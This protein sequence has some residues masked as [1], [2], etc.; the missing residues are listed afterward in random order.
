[1]QRS[2]RNYNDGKKCES[3]YPAAWSVSC[4]RI[5]ARVATQ[6][7]ETTS[8]ADSF[9][10]DKRR[11]F[12]CEMDRVGFGC[13]QPSHGLLQRANLSYHSDED[14]QQCI[15]NSPS[16]TLANPLLGV[17]LSLLS[18]TVFDTACRPPGYRTKPLLVTVR[19]TGGGKTRLLEEI[20]RDLQRNHSVLPIAITF[21]GYTDFD[22][23]EF[24]VPSAAVSATLSI[25]ARMAS[26][27][28]DQSF[29]S[30]KD[31]MSE[32]LPRRQHKLH[33]TDLYTA[34]VQLMRQQM[35][36]AGCPVEIFVLMIDETVRL[37]S[38]LLERYPDDADPLSELRRVFL[39][40]THNAA[41]VLSSLETEIKGIFNP[42][43]PVT[44]LLLCEALEVTRDPAG[45][46]SRTASCSTASS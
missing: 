22:N 15:I 4:E 33:A 43:R 2:K 25:I 31:A 26:A 13:M 18:K 39:D 12:V 20:R 17:D 14:T 21:N 46:A 23:I 34:F 24:H 6:V 10:S 36:D 40:Q 19:G 3:V 11:S 35:Q 1:M 8:E 41:L 32:A 44:P 38:Q 16:I 27:F 45:G 7:P 5:R 37:Q 28:Y 29:R 42:G 9:T 30:V